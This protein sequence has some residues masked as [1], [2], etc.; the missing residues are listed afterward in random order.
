MQG[1]RTE[2]GMARGRNSE[3]QCGRSPVSKEGEQMRQGGLWLARRK[4]A[5]SS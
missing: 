3:G 1:P 2:R 4:S 5:V